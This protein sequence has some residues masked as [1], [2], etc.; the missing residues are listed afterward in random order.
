V[1]IIGINLGIEANNSGIDVKACRWFDAD[2]K[3]NSLLRLWS[4]RSRSLPIRGF[5]RRS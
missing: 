1:I 2:D 5:R 4:E 3:L